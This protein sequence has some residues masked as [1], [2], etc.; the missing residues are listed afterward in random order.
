MQDFCEAR[1]NFRMGFLSPQGR[2]PS[3]GHCK[4]VEI[5]SRSPRTC[6]AAVPKAYLYPLERPRA[7]RLRVPTKERKKG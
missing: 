3:R 2:R 1:G 6:G 4:H 7:V 5:D